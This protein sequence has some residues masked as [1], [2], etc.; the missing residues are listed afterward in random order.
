[1]ILHPPGLK[2]RVLP[3]VAEHQQALPLRVVH[4]VLRQDVHVGHVDRAHRPGRLAVA[5]A[6]AAAVGAAGEAA[7]QAAGVL[8]VLAHGLQRHRA[9][10]GAARPAARRRLRVRG[11]AAAA[12]VERRRPRVAGRLFR[13]LVR[14]ADQAVDQHDPLAALRL[15]QRRPPGAGRADSPAAGSGAGVAEVFQEREVVVLPAGRAGR[16]GK[17]RVA[18]AWLAALAAGELVFGGQPQARPGAV[19]REGRHGAADAAHEAVHDGPQQRAAVRARRRAQRQPGEN[20]GLGDRPPEVSRKGRGQLGERFGHAEFFVQPEHDFVARQSGVERGRPISR[21]QLITGQFGVCG[22]HGGRSIVSLVDRLHA[23]VQDGRGVLPRRR[24]RNPR[25]CPYFRLVV[26]ADRPHRGG[27]DAEEARRERARGRRFPVIDDGRRGGDAGGVIR[28]GG[29]ERAQAPDQA[30]GLRAKRAGEGMRFVEHQEVEPRRGEQLDVLLAG[31]QQ[32]QL[33][34]VGEQHPRLPARRAHHLPRAD[35]LGRVHGLAAA[36]ALRPPQPRLVVGPRGAG[37]Q[38]DAG[39]VGFA[40]RRLAD[41]DAE[42]NAGAGQQA[43]QAHELVFGQRVHRIDDDGADAGRRP[44]IAQPQTLADDGVEEALG[45]AGTG[46]GG[47]QRGPAR[48]DGA[49]RLFLVTAEMGDRGRNPLAQVRM[50]HPFGDQRLDRAAVA[51][52][53]GQ[54]DVR[55]LEQRRAARPVERQQLPHLPVQPRIGERVRRKLV[56]QEAAHDVLGIGDRI[57]RHAATE[58]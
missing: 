50:E 28:L 5:A 58:S 12:E 44:L 26:L 30:G 33:L 40:L 15:L 16:Y 10:G 53:T 32:L 22:A 57:Q 49:Y 3:V 54:A 31:E 19:V 42:R 2:R 23:T 9:A 24:G 34:H 13:I 55:P 20:L 29:A 46:A 48:G 7:R 47:D 25:R 39:H 52:R 18:G 11:A 8:R 51:E 4:H 17:V 56:A 38:P 21:R 14:C 43:A 35:F 41:V 1:M 45:L 37:P 36:L 27:G 6:H